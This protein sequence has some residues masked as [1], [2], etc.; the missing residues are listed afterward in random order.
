LL[1]GI[2]QRSPEKHEVVPATISI[3]SSP[4]EEILGRVG[5]CIECLKIFTSKFVEAVPSTNKVM[6]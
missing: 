4:D 5:V 1:T 6:F 3:F 2:A